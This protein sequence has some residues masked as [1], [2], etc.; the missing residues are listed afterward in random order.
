MKITTIAGRMPQFAQPLLAGVCA[1]GLL[2]ATLDASPAWARDDARPS[3]SPKFVAAAQPM[4]T[5]IDAMKAKKPDA[6]A[7]ASA[8]TQLGVTLAAA[9]TPDDKLLAGQFAYQV[10]RLGED[11]QTEIRGLRMMIDSGKAPASSVPQ[12]HS[13]LGGLSFDEKD[14][15]T[16]RTEL[17]A[18]IAAGYSDANTYTALAETDFATKQ[19]AAGLAALQKAIDMRKAAGQPVPEGWYRRAFEVAYTAKLAEQTRQLGLELVTASPSKTNWHDAI[20]GLRANSTFS[21]GE[22]LDLLRLMGATNSYAD[23]N[24]YLTH[25]ELANPR[26]LPGEAQS[27]LQAGLAAGVLSANAMSVQDDQAAIKQILAA[28]HAS[29]MA[30]EREA[31]APGTTATALSG[32]GSG[33]LSYG[34]M[35]K[36]VEIYQLA[37]T[38]PGAEADLL[39]T[40]LGIAQVG[41]GDYAGARASFAKVGGARVPIAQLWAAYAA[42]KAGGK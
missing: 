24:D 41:A 1:L 28:D 36:A 7:I 12:L 26:R 17:E 35:A 34:E 27:V 20:N 10:G 38:K 21:P 11:R 31:H 18:A 42:Q 9:T 37:L 6:A 40:R 2:G 39:N 15:A 14:Y 8:N 13:V 25:I 5:T 4:Q 32:I 19:A 33:F 23:A 29:V 16:A 30:S 3:Y 22:S